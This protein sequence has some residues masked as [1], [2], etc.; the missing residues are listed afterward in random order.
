MEHLVFVSVRAGVMV[1]LLV[2]L[3]LLSMLKLVVSMVVLVMGPLSTPYP[4]IP[5]SLPPC[6]YSRST[7]SFTRHFLLCPTAVCEFLIDCARD[8]FFAPTL[9]TP[10]ARRFK[11]GTVEIPLVFYEPVADGFDE[12]VSRC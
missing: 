1:V 3:V 6:L 4:S 12:T 7:P 5:L 2:L 11:P 9:P 8:M 10:P